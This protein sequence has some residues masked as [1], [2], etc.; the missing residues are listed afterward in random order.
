MA[1][2]FR[3]PMAMTTDS[4][5]PER[6]WRPSVSRGVDN[7]PATL[8]MGLAA[9]VLAL[10]LGHRLLVSQAEPRVQ[11]HAHTRRGTLPST[12]R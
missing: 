9:S 3:L 12:G 10:R 2:V 4:R 5:T 7:E 1:E 6:V 11:A 8:G